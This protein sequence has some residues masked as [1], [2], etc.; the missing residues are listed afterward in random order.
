MSDSRKSWI[1][2][3]SINIA[4]VLLQIGK[5]ILKVSTANKDA[6]LD[7]VPV[8][9]V[10]DTIICAAWHVTLHRD[11]KP[12]VYNCTSNASPLR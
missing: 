1:I 9:Y 11:N 10:I 3:K 5:G 8:D 6:N 4:A 12:K 7:L 2:S